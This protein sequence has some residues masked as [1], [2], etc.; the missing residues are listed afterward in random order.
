MQHAQQDNG[1]ANHGHVHGI[2][3][4]FI[5]HELGG[6]ELYLVDVKCMRKRYTGKDGC[7]VIQVHWFRNDYTP[8]HT[9]VLGQCKK[10]NVCTAG[11]SGWQ[12]FTVIRKTGRGCH[13]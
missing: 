4:C 1:D 12:Q 5:Q 8:R 7:Y 10:N 13:T 3:G 11:C 2:I 9:L 6:G